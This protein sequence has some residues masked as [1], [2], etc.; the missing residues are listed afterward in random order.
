MKKKIV[1]II[2]VVIVVTAAFF[3][4]FNFFANKDEAD[5][6][7]TGTNYEEIYYYVPGE[8]FV[9]NIVDS[10]ALCKTSTSLALSGKD[11]T[12]FLETNVAVIRNEIVKVLRSHNEEDLRTPGAIDQ[13]E[14]EMTVAIQEELQLTDLVQVFISDFVIQ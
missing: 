7:A 8:Y 9:T 12:T 11:Q 3:V 1:P 14:Q 6:G 4:Y 10:T 5:Q 2:I 13:L